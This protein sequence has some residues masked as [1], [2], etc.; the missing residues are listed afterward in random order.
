VIET[1]L[2]RAGWTPES[3]DVVGLV[4]GSSQTLAFRRMISEMFDPDR[5]TIPHDAE[6][7]VA[8]G[9][10]LLTARHQNTTSAVRTLVA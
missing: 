5:V 1:G 7:A 4:G 2:A 8:I 6:T 9:A 10:T 3:V